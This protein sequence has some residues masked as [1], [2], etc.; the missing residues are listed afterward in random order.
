VAQ[1]EGDSARKS[2]ISA[3]YH[4][5]LAARYRGPTNNFTLDDYISKHVDTNAELLHLKEVIS[6]FTKVE[7]FI[8]G[9]LDPRLKSTKE[10]VLGD[11]T[12]NED[13]LTTQ[14]YFMA[15]A[16]NLVDQDK[17]RSSRF[18]HGT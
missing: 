13:I 17:V 9:I 7:D 5:I 6:E 11:R 18:R 1:V 15:V 16:S 12:K 3:A 14:Q 4:N 8:R 10:I 2:R